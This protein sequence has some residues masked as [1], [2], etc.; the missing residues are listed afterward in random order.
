[1]GSGG[2]GKVVHGLWESGSGPLLLPA[3]WVLHICSLTSIGGVSGSPDVCS[4]Y[5]DAHLEDK[6][7]GE[8]SCVV[9]P[10]CQP[11][12]ESQR[13]G[14]HESSHPEDRLD[15]ATRCVKYGAD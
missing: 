7:L 14:G 13:S 6:V 8:T 15:L 12:S 9:P 2:G 5:T 1:M 10:Y 11:C 4:V 3:L